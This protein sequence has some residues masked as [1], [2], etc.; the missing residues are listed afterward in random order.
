M[1]ARDLR[2]SHG[3]LDFLQPLYLKAPVNSPVAAATTWLAVVLMGTYDKGRPYHLERQLLTKVVENTLVALKDP[4]LSLKDETLMVV[5]ILSYGEHLRNQRYG[6]QSSA[7]IIHQQGAEALIRKRGDLNF[8]NRTALSLFDAIRHNAV[9]QAILEV[10][11][12]T[13]WDLWD[14][15][16]NTAQLCDSYTPATELDA[17]AVTV[18]TLKRR[19]KS[20]A[21]CADS[22]LRKDVLELTE[23][24]RLWPSHAPIDWLPQQGPFGLDEDLAPEVTYLFYQWHLLQVVMSHLTKELDMRTDPATT[25]QTWDCSTE[26][27]CIDKLIKCEDVLLSSCS[28]ESRRFESAEETPAVSLPKRFPRATVEQCHQSPFGSRLVRQTLV[29]LNSILSKALQELPLPTEVA[30]RY[31]EVVSWARRESDTIGE[32][33]PLAAS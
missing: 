25:L 32:A 23:R 33:F 31:A 11:K 3:H 18:E 5:L 9:N 16:Q 15:D 7:S 22:T 1:S 21:L 2:T 4:T 27:Q 24:L 30:S 6:R 19:V 14:L 28:K 8:R 17:C 10:R 13:N 20:K 26:L 12:P 29:K